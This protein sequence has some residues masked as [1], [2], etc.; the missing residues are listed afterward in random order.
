MIQPQPHGK[1]KNHNNIAK[2]L[3]QIITSLRII[4]HAS[5]IA[6]ASESEVQSIWNAIKLNTLKSEKHNPFL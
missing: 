3:N 4:F 6:N 2:C 1:Q 5:F